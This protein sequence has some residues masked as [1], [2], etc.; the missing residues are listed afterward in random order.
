MNRRQYAG[1]RSHMPAPEETLTPGPKT[2]LTPS[3]SLYPGP[4]AGRGENFSTGR[5]Q[6]LLA[7][8]AA[9]E[10][11][12][13]AEPDVDDAAQATFH[14]AEACIAFQPGPGPPSG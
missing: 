7:G 12:R 3:P 11:G 13:N 1:P 4:T 2:T 9:D 6:A 5:Q 14:G 8:L 10:R